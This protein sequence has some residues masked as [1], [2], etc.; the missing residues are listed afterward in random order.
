M[1]T[2]VRSL[3]ESFEALS[4]PERQEAALEILRRLTPEGDLP[5][6]ALV[7]AADELFVALDAEEASDAR[8]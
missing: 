8:S 4:E 5:E 2:A 1:T 7:E 6:Q 3:I